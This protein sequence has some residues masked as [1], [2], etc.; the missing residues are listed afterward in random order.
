MGTTKIYNQIVDTYV[1]ENENRVHMKLD[2]KKFSSLMPQN[3]R[4]I[5]LGCG[6]GFDSRDLKLARKDLQIIGIDNSEE[7]LK[8]FSK[9]TS[10]IP[11]ENKDI[12]SV[13]FERSA[14]DGVW[15]N[16]SLLHLTKEDGK[17]LLGRIL[18]WLKPGGYL[19]LQLKKGEGEKEVPA[20]KYGRSDLSRFYSFYDENELKKMLSGLGYA[21]ESIETEKR[22]SEIWIKV[23]ASNPL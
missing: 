12:L 4:V 18:F 1:S 21:V 22:K 3:A 2:V 20:S 8:Q 6:V 5:D 10:S 15:M 9:I 13:V 14:L 17:T 23:F 7:M 19:Y 16:A 11:T